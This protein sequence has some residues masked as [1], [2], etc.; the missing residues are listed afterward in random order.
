[1]ARG[2]RRGARLRPRAQGRQRRLRR[3]RQ[4]RPA[5]SRARTALDAVLVN[6]DI[7]FTRARLARRACARAPTPRAARP[8]SSARRLL[9]P[10]G[11]LQHAGV[12]FSLPQPRL[13]HRF[14]TRPPTCPRRCVAVPL[15]GDRRAAADPPRDARRRRHLRRGASGSR[16]RTSTTAC[17]CSRPALE[18]IYEPAA[19]AFHHESLFRGTRSK[20]DRGLHRRSIVRL[21]R[22]ARRDRHEPLRPRRSC[23][24]SS[25]APSSSAAAHRRPPGTAA[26]CP[27]SRSAPTGSASRGEPP[28]L[29]FVTGDTGRE[30]ALDATSRLRRRRRP[31]AARA[32]SGSRRSATAGAGRRRC[33]TRSTTDSHAVRKID[34]P[35]ARERVR[36]QGLVAQFELGM[37]VADGVICSTECLAAPLRAR[38]TRDVCVCRNGIDLRRYALTPPGARHR[39]RSAGPA[40]RA[41]RAAMRPWLPRSR[42]VMRARPRRPLR[43]RRRSRSRTR[44]PRSSAPSA[45]SRAVRAARDLPGGDDALRHRARARRR[46]RT[47]S[48]ARATCAGSRRARSAS[49]SIADPDVYPDIEHGVTGFHAATPA[50]AARAPARAG[51][52]RASCASA[53]A[54]PRTSTS[55]S[56]AASRSAPSEWAEVLARR[57]RRRP[58]VA[59]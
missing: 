48:A 57:R 22:E 40:A 35:R 25:P 51:R 53:S 59:A 28:N 19:V 21:L 33:S 58:R 3:R 49:R 42:E 7:E 8:P 11:L 1:M 45:R 46:R 56:T 41:T 37:R 13:A 9:Y 16:T 23:E 36:P 54:R 24:P 44:S 29:R 50:E 38:S 17:A 15:P 20:H 52:R 10:N 12:Y 31:A 32:P 27:P 55:P 6:A 43:Q 18:C 5:R 26:R 47:S 2:R 34:G 14:T 4:R 30:R 39:R